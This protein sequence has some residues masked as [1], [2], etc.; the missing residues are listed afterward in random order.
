MSPD[1]LAALREELRTKP[2]QRSLETRASIAL[3]HRLLVEAALR[4]YVGSRNHRA[5]C[6]HRDLGRYQAS[7][8]QRHCADLECSHADARLRLFWRILK[9][10]DRVPGVSYLNRILRALPTR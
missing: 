8:W 1:D 6:I 2:G 3:Q 9:A 4:F 10:H 5:E 7:T